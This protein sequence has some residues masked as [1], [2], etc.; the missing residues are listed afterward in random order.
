MKICKKGHEYEM[1]VGR[2]RCCPICR[3]E[4]GKVYNKIYQEK[5][6][7]ACKLRYKQHRDANRER[8]ATQAKAWRAANKQRV[9]EYAYNYVRNKLDSDPFYKFKHN[10]KNL[11]KESFK[12]KFSRKKSRTESILGCNFEV[13]QAHLWKTA[14]QNYGFYCPIYKYEIDHKIPLA[15]AKS[16]E[17]IIKLN[18]YTNLQYLY[19]SDNNRKSAKLDWTAADLTDGLKDIKWR[20]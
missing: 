15:T 6:K 14:V 8:R 20:A 19:P 1:V 10:V 7:E 13:L 3:K 18:H 11:I 5:N 2:K 4:Y 16:E 9:K 17:D 12:K